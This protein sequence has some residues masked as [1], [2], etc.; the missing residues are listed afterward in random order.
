MWAHKSLSW[1]M[2]PADCSAS[3]SPLGCPTLYSLIRRSYAIRILPSLKI[4]KHH[5]KQ[6]LRISRDYKKKQTLEVI[7]ES[8]LSL[9]CI[10]WKVLLVLLSDCI[11]NL[12]T[13]PLLP[14]LGYWQSLLTTPCFNPCPLVYF[15][16]STHKDSLK[17]NSESVFPQKSTTAIALVPHNSVILLI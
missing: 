8:S 9:T 5:M 14:H 3:T 17:S 1:Y 10:H 15:P 4:L 16:Q 13:D 7:L 12:T 6:S 2:N 11:H